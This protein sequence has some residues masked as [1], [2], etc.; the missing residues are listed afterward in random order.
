MV[1]SYLIKIIELRNQFVAFGMKT[2][3]EELVLRATNRISSSWEPF[4]YGICLQEFSLLRGAL[5]LF[6][7]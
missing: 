7:P 3:N 1:A 6:N 2:K 5:G 4:V